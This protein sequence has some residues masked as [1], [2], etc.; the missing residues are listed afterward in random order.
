MTAQLAAINA[1]KLLCFKVIIFFPFFI[2]SHVDL[3]K[4]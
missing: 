1:S 2:I 4:C 3:F